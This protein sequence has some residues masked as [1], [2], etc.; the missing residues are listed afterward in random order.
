M[1]HDHTM[2]LLNLFQVT[3]SSQKE[4]EP[5]SFIYYRCANG[6]R[7]TIALK[8]IKGIIK[9]LGELQQMVISVVTGTSDTKRNIDN[10]IALV[11][12][13]IRSYTRICIRADKGNSDL[14]EMGKK[15]MYHQKKMEPR[16]T[17]K[18]ILSF[19]L[20]SKITKNLFVS[21]DFLGKG[22]PPAHQPASSLVHHD[23]SHNRRGADYPLRRKVL[24][25]SHWDGGRGQ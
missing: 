14:T 23:L 3:L 20:F 17:Y 7:V 9:T 16:I 24:Q 19:F 18:A 8:G 10:E 22:C 15:M 1:F 12:W 5:R 11:N 2:C 4:G 6:I 25:K 21:S 13:W